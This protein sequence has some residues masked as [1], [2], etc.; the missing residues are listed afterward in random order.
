MFFDNPNLECFNSI[1]NQ[2]IKFC[3]EIFS[4][5][6]LLKNQEIFDDFENSNGGFLIYMK[7]TCPYCIKAIQLMETNSFSFN[8]VNVN[9]FASRYNF[10]KDTMNVRT[11]P[12]IFD[13]RE[14]K[15]I[16]HI[17]GCDD[18]INFLNKK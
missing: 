10:I 15:N 5:A 16:K 2:D 17:G 13:V 18:F 9:E 11:V 14:S 7:P 6:E 8:K 3:T 4:V 1:K 12:Q